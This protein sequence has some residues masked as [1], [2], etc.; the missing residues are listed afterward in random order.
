MDDA[1]W[2]SMLAY[3]MNNLIRVL[4][5]TI[6]G[7]KALVSFLVVLTLLSFIAWAAVHWGLA[8]L[9]WDAV[10]TWM[11]NVMTGLGA[12]ATEKM[13]RDAKAAANGAG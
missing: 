5:P 8:A 13:K 6:D 4:R 11:R 1:A 2:V 3:I 9:V 7:M 10:T 12:F